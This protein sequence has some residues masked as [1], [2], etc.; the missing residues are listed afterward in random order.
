LSFRRR[1]IVILTV[2]TYDVY[3][4]TSRKSCCERI[5]L[6][7]ISFL[8]P[9]N[10]ISGRLLASAS[11]V[12]FAWIFHAIARIGHIASELIRKLRGGWACFIFSLSF[13]LELAVS[14]LCRRVSDLGATYRLLRAYRPLL[15]QSDQAIGDSPLI[16]EVL[17]HSLVLHFLFSRA[18]LDMRSPHQVTRLDRSRSFL[19]SFF[20]AYPFCRSTAKLI[21][22]WDLH[23]LL[24]DVQPREA[25]NAAKCHFLIYLPKSF[26]RHC[27]RLKI[28]TVHVESYPSVNTNSV[29]G[30][31]K[32]SVLFWFKYK[33]L[34]ILHS[35]ESAWCSRT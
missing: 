8:D 22:M 28:V 16:G 15:F 3:S 13:Q 25:R 1:T 2:S 27:L 20:F 11:R 10:R 12:C 33:P 14:P 6:N 18:P 9:P 21:C 29:F 34:Q 4:I 5:C 30:H 35:S 19:V 17:P 23:W 31:G 32:A 24:I 26:L 7:P